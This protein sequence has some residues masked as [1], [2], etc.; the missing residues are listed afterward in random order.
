MTVVENK[1]YIALGDDKLRN[2][3]RGEETLIDYAVQRRYGRKSL[4]R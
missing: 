4:E 2:D 3:F 1:V